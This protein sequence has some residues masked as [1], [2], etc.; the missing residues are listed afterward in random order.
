MKIKF[1]E[2]NGVHRTMG[3][4][5]KISNTV[6]RNKG[7]GFELGCLGRVEGMSASASSFFFFLPS[8]STK[9]G[10]GFSKQSII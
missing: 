2:Q 4:L 10:H 1:I 9:Q 5:R 7:D 8:V 6:I 3:Y